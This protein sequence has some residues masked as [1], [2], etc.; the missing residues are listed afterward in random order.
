MESRR[1]PPRKPVKNTTEILLGTLGFH[2]NMPCPYI[3]VSY[4]V[5]YHAFYRFP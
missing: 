2:R 5:S 3:E 4:E 1:F